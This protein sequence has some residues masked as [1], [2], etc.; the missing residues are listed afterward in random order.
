MMRHPL[1]DR[2]TVAADNAAAAM[3]SSLE[4]DWSGVAAKLDYLVI[5]WADASGVKNPATVAKAQEAALAEFEAAFDRLFDE[6][7]GRQQ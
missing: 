3:F 6:W 4:R 2:A 5:A 1:S 7:R